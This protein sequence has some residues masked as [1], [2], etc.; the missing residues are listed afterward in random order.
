MGQIICYGNEARQKVYDGIKKVNQAVA[1]TLGP[2][3]RRVIISKLYEPFYEGIHKPIHVT[4]DGVTTAKSINLAD[5]FENIGQRLI[6]EAAQKTVDLAGDAT[7]TTCVLLESLVFHGLKLI[8]GGINPQELKKGIDKAV[9]EVIDVLRKKAIPIR[10]GEIEK[11]RQIATVSANNDSSVGDLIAQ[12]FEKIG[13]DGVIDIQPSKTYTTEVKIAE[14]FKFDNGWLLP[15]FKTNEAKNECE[16]I[17]PLILLYERNI[18]QQAQIERAMQICLSDSRPLLVICEDCE[19]Q[20]LAML[21][22]NKYKKT[23]ASCVVKSPF[24]GEART[25]AMEDIAAF[26]GGTFMVNTKGVK[27]ENI[28][29]AQMGECEKVIVGKESTVIIGGRRGNDYQEL[30]DDLKM[31]LASEGKS[32]EEKAVTEKRIARLMGGVA[33]IH[34]GAATETEMNE[35]IDRVDDAVRATK[36]AIAEGYLPGGGSELARFSTPVKYIAG[37]DPYSNTKK[38]WQIW[39]KDNKAIVVKVYKQ[40]NGNLVAEYKSTASLDAMTSARTLVNR[41]LQ[42]PLN[43]ICRNAGV[44]AEEILLKVQKSNAQMGYNA[45]TDKIENLIEAGIIDP[46]KVIRCALQNAASV[47]GNLLISEAVIADTQN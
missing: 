9:E 21:V 44:D 7:T 35:K 37:V 10:D 46:L 29:K 15:H 33:V 24:I 43:Q 17:N 39:R 27:L 20:A 41:S 5:P 4:K 13:R 42:E 26:T 6:Q 36:A 38:W 28:T 11:I 22:M 25:Q 31:D 30:L 12:A 18:S 14:G 40:H 45:K 34:V 47:A 32:E 1:A 19:M 8:D 3:G 16:L 23:L 2:M